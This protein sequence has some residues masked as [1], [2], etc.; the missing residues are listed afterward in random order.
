MSYAESVIHKRRQDF[1]T[2]DMSSVGSVMQIP[3]SSADAQSLGI[4]IIY[5]LRVSYAVKLAKLSFW[6]H[7]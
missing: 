7:L 3:V 6:T 1:V 2:Q 4:V 5:L